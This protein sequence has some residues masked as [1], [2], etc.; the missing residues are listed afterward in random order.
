MEEI[1]FW[2][3]DDRHL[4]E[5]LGNTIKELKEIG[6]LKE[7]IDRIESQ[8]EF[9]TNLKILLEKGL[10]RVMYEDN[11]ESEDEIGAIEQQIKDNKKFLELLKSNV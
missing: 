11:S 7:T 9:H 6:M 1:F 2:L 10:V 3:G 8:I 5:D 4:V